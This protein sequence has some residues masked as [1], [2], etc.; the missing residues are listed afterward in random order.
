MQLID[1]ALVL[2]GVDAG[3]HGGK[4]PWLGGRG[5]REQEHAVGVLH[6]PAQAHEVALA[7]EG[8]H[9]KPVGDALAEGAQ[10]RIDVVHEL[11]AALVPAEAGDD[12]VEDEHR[13]MAVAELANPAKKPGAGGS[14]VS[15]SRI[16]AAIRSGWVGNSFSMLSRSL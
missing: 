1:D 11:G 15:A 12:L 5:L 6:E 2:V 3:E 4:H 9:G 7:G 16:T 10:V 13:A 8:R 14:V